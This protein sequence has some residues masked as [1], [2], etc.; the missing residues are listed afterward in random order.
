MKAVLSA[1]HARITGEGLSDVTLGAFCKR[2]LDAKA[3]TVA[4]RSRVSYG[5]AISE[6]LRILP[7]RSGQ[8]L[9]KLTA[10]DVRRFAHTRL[11][12]TTP[13]TAAN[14]LKIV[15]MLLRAAVRE[16]LIDRNPGEHVEAPRQGKAHQR[17]AFTADQ[18][19]T[20]LANA[21]G[22]WRSLCLFGIFS[23]AR[24]G[25]LVRLRWS[26]I[27]TIES[28]LRFVTHKTGR[29]VRIPLAAPLLE[30]IGSLDPPADPSAPLHTRALAI[31]EREGGRVG[32]LSREF[33]DLL[34]D[35]GLR[36]RPNRRGG[37]T[38][39]RGPREHG[40]LSFH[41]LRRFVVTTLHEGGVALGVAQE[42]TGHASASEHQGYLRVSREAMERAVAS[43][44]DLS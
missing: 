6:L 35:C 13:R 4:P 16:G 19:R 10:D 41:G 14:Q 32:S 2:W 38:G 25:D 27:D 7:E 42:F 26:N 22:E 24:L 43:L 20:L 9:G 30:F 5:D 17:P 11:E 34:A 29:S 21:T 39:R 3:R 28:E 15:K 1:A 31:C 12:E 23:G 44:P 37:G 40:G 36:S 18:L 33:A 8:P